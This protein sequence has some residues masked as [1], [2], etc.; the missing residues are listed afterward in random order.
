M[1]GLGLDENIE[2]YLFSR[3][4]NVKGLAC[5]LTGLL[6]LKKLEPLL[7][8]ARDIHKP[9]RIYQQGIFFNT[10]IA[11]LAEEAKMRLA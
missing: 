3:N 11:E 1:I 8:P 5:K 6:G 10:T 7:E 4:H 2:V 9:V